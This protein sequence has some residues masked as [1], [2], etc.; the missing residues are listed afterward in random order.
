MNIALILDNIRSAYNVGSIFRTSDGAGISYIYICGYTPTPENYKVCKTSLGAEKAIP[1][2]YYKNI[3]D[4]IKNLKSQNYKILA[5][6]TSKA[7]K[8]YNEYDFIDNTALILG[9]EKIGIE[10]TTLDQC[11]DIII[12]DMHGKKQSLNVAV[13]AGIISFKVTEHVRGKE[14]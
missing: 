12:I 8:S 7:A 13:T 4:C 9:N 10:K 3:N 6:E 5:I 2:T 1:W 11:D 14:K